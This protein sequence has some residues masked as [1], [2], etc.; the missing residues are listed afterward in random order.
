MHV[1]IFRLSLSL[2]LHPYERR[3]RWWILSVVPPLDEARRDLLFR[4]SVDWEDLP[5]S[6]FNYRGEVLLL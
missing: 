4:T 5:V 3:V 1:E 6:S 2:S